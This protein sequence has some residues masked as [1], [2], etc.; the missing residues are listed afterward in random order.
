MKARSVAEPGGSPSA[1]G[2]A[3]GLPTGGGTAVAQ[4]LRACS[5]SELAATAARLAGQLAGS[6]ALLGVCVPDGPFTVAALAAARLAGVP[7]LLLPPDP[8]SRW[9]RDR[10]REAGC[11]HLTMA[12]DGGGSG[13]ALESLGPP[14]PDG[15]A[16]PGEPG[17]QLLTSGTTGAPKTVSHTWS[18]LAASVVCRPDLRT[19]RWMSLYPLTRFAGLNTLLHALL[20][21][22]LLVVPSAL[23]A[24]AI[25][26]DW[27]R[28]APTHL[29][30]TPTLWKNLLMALPRDR[31]FTEPVRQIT[32]GGEVVDQ[33]I[34]TALRRTFPRARL[35]HVYAST[36]LGVCLSVS[37]GL[38][39]F[40]RAWLG[41]EHRGVTLQVH[42][43]ELR[44]RRRPSEEPAAGPARAEWWPTGD[45]VEV[46]GDRVF[47]RGRRS[48]L[49]NV[50]GAKVAPGD[51]EARLLEVPGV[52]AAL[53]SGRRSSLA[54]AVLVAHL[55]LEPGAARNVVWKMALAHC[56]RALPPYAVP[57]IV[58]FVRRLPVAA[59]GKVERETGGRDLS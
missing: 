34:L 38:A 1:V 50:G 33:T 53:V 57:R 3:H 42:E 16:A 9:A 10:A 28:W 18:R 5:W 36:E 43:D 17:M 41:L 14:C 37:D 26:E 49:V 52:A 51:V 23:T 13:V 20:N 24:P 11:T 27:E 45:L 48:D 59:S 8:G 30:G 19:A 56:Q 21:E 29:A 46:R 35:T 39:G 47:F 25:L 2:A 44:V 4:G 32:L 6:G 54:G 31:S 55:V 58:E 15:V 12:E 7:A 22:T 40:P